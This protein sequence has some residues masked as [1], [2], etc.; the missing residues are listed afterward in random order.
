[1]ASS[2]HECGG[3]D[4]NLTHSVI[5]ACDLT[6]K[7]ACP[8]S[9]NSAV[10]FF[11]SN[12]SSGQLKSGKKEEDVMDRR[13]RILTLLSLMLLPAASILGQGQASSPAPVRVQR[14]VM[15]ELLMLPY[16]GVSTTSNTK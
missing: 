4:Q 8:A 5:V 11:A 15:H 14:E 16:F 10:E 12:R 1:M 13:F 7:V 6:V 3:V 9:E 2:I